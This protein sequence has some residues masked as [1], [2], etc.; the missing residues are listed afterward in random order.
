MRRMR[1]S[2]RQRGFL[3]IAAVFLLV[4]L[5][6]LVGYMLTVSTTSQAASAADFNSAR[7]YQAARAGLEWGAYRILRGAGGATTFETQCAA[8]SATPRNL[9]FGSAL[10]GFTATVSCTAGGLTEGA[11]SV[12]AYKI[13]SVGCNDAS[14]PNASTTSATYVERALTLSLTK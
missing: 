5:A 7:A 6:G 3:V 13:I 8:G 4:V 14:C 1:T 10:A 9:T 12:T 11:S 2:R